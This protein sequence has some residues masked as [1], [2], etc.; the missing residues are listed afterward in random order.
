VT[1]WTVFW[2]LAAS[3]FIVGLMMIGLAAVLVWY[4]N[5]RD[6][7]CDQTIRELQN[8]SEAFSRQTNDN[9]REM[10][11]EGIKVFSDVRDALTS[12]TMASAKVLEFLARQD[13]ESGGDGVYPPKGT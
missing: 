11:K 10:F 12:S 3:V 13:D 1:Y 6:S 9:I 5:R 4:L 8:K 2:M 7:R